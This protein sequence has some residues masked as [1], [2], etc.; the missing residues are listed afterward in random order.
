MLFRFTVLL[1]LNSLRFLFSDQ[2]STLRTVLKSNKLTAE[3]ALASLRDKYEADKK[4][5]QVRMLYTLFSIFC[6][7]DYNAIQ[8]SSPDCS[9]RCQWGPISCSSLLP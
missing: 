7:V 4:A 9:N 1:Y 2:I 6:G 3:S 8:S 5:H